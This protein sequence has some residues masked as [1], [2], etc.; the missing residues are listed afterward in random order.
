MAVPTKICTYSLPDLKNTTDDAVA[1]QYLATKS[2]RQS[3]TLTD[4]RLGLSTAACVVA[5]TTFY[6]D[7]TQ[8]FEPTKSFTFYAC[9]VYFTLNALLT[10]WLYLF[11]GSTIYVGAHKTA[12]VSL[13]LASSVVRHDPTYRLKIIQSQV[14]DGRKVLREREVE[15][16][17]AS[18]FDERGFFVRRPFETWMGSVVPWIL[19]NEDVPKELASGVVTASGRA[20]EDVM[21]GTEIGSGKA[22]RRKGAKKT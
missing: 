2:F 15:C 19:E 5:A 22:G 20:V 13:T 3:H 21:P 1:T 17:F 9:I 4:V 7:Y 11:E 18:W 6:L 10:G 12:D 14:V 16:P 8:G